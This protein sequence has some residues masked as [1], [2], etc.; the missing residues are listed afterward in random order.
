MKVVFVGS[1]QSG[2]K[3]QQDLVER[4]DGRPSSA[5]RRRS[6]LFTL[7]DRRDPMGGVESRQD[8][9]ADAVTALGSET[10]PIDLEPSRARREILTTLRQ[11]ENEP[12]ALQLQRMTMAAKRPA[13]VWIVD[14]LGPLLSA[15]SIGFK[16]AVLAG[17]PILKHRKS[18]GQ[19]HQPFPHAIVCQSYL[20]EIVGVVANEPSFACG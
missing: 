2:G 3:C 16:G 17:K 8:K 14:D 9:I 4:Q 13:A 10:T 12:D 19:P 7:I 5:L 1:V 15:G 18:F 11:P 6:E 20:I